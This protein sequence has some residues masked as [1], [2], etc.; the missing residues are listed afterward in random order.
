MRAI[1]RSRRQRARLRAAARRALGAL[2]LSAALLAGTLAVG[3]ASTPEPPPLASA[4]ELREQDLMLR[5]VEALDTS[6]A[7]D[8]DQLMNRLERL[9]PSWQAEQRKGRA[10]AI[11]V[12]ITSL[13]VPQY[14]IVREMFRSGP[15]E[16]RLVAAWALGFTRVPN[17]DL[18]IASMHIDAQATLVR[19]LPTLPDDVLAN[20]LL[21]LWKIG[22]P[23]TPVDALADLIL[24]HHDALVR[25]N[26]T[27]ALGRV[28]REDTARRGVEAVLVALDD[29]DA[30]V[31]VHAASVARSF[32]DRAYLARLESL[33]AEETTPLA[34]ARMASALG[35]LGSPS[36]AH[37]LIPLLR[38][39]SELVA[40]YAREA[41]VEI[42]GEDRGRDPAAWHELVRTRNR[43]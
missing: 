42:F 25:A 15:H 26:A 8:P 13:V 39:E 1:R 28:L 30:T 2:P 23:S 10:D 18:G 37:L 22:E 11:E 7:V 5:L 36:S 14:V 35:A 6:T 43:G 9:L 27:L 33:I 29:V 3:C 12:V 16:R 4:E 17:N 41:L 20:A 38:G 32:P 19:A 21:A 40:V 31:R 24:N 34:Q